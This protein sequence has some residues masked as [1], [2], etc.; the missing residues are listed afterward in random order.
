VQERE[1]L[2]G[3][4]FIGQLEHELNASSA[5]RVD[6]GA[7]ISGDGSYTAEDTKID[8]SINPMGIRATGPTLTGTFTMTFTVSGYSGSAAF[9]GAL[10]SVTR[11]S[12]TASPA[13]ASAFHFAGIRELIDAA[14]HR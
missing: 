8:T 1:L 14:R 11:S 12:S 6:G 9:D 4:V 13:T 2:S 10:A 7:A 3:S 5:I